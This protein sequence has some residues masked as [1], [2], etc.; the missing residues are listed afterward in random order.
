MSM[1][2]LANH[3]QSRWEALAQANIMYARPMLEMDEAAARAFLD[4]E[5]VMGDVSGRAVLCLAG[6]GGQQSAAFALLG[7][8]VTV[9]DFS[10]TQLERDRQAADHYGVDVTTLE[11]D[12]RD[13]SAFAD[14]AFDIVYH[15]HSLTFVPDCGTVFD[16]VARV[17]RPGGL[18]RLH[19]TNP[20]FHHMLGSDWS[21]G[22]QLTDTYAD[23]EVVSAD[24]CWDVDDGKGNV[25][26]VEGPRE[27]RHTL[28]TVVNGLIERRFELLGLWEDDRGDPHAE[29]GTWAHMKSVAPPWLTTWWRLIG[30]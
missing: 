3:N 8:N 30:S 7:A 5:G 6:G 18:Y 29:P 28:S 15:A 25:Q 9:L 14:R 27:F 13:L 23:G 19:W 11:G 17:L 12:M 1:D 16:E 24:P 2:E 22:Y 26:Q 10:P 21:G 20:F 4:P